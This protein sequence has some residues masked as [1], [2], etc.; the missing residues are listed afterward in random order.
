M[1]KRKPNFSK[2]KHA[3][4]AAAAAADDD[5]EKNAGLRDSVGRDSVGVDEDKDYG[6]SLHLQV[7]CYCPQ[8]ILKSFREAPLYQTLG[9]CGG[10]INGFESL[11]P[12]DAV[13]IVQK[14]KTEGFL[15]CSI[16]VNLGTNP[17]KLLHG[18]RCAARLPGAGPAGR[19][20]IKFQLFADDTALVP[21]IHG[22]LVM[23]K[24]KLYICII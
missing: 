18:Q 9:S 23:T 16:R 1:K 11:V 5:V 8:P 12:H 19:G 13:V 24:R 2:K 15:G 7:E 17:D 6:P 20:N 10:R 22:R 14:E 4:A 3:K 21:G